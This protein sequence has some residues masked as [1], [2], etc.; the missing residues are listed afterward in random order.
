MKDISGKKVSILSDSKYQLGKTQREIKEKLKTKGAEIVSDYDKSDFI[1]LGKKNRSLHFLNDKHKILVEAELEAQEPKHFTYFGGLAQKLFDM[2][3]QLIAMDNVTVDMFEI[4]AGLTEKEFATIEKRLKKPLPKSVKEFYS[5]FG[6]VKMLWHF[7]NPPVSYRG[8]YHKGLYLHSG[9]HNGCINILPLRKFLFENWKNPEL[10]LSLPADKDIRLFDLYADYHIIGCELSNDE[11]PKVYLGSDHG[12]NFELINDL[13]FSVY[14]N[15]VIGIYGYVNRFTNTKQWIIG[16]NGYIFDQFSVEDIKD[17]ENIQKLSTGF[18]ALDSANAAEIENYKR[19]SWEEI[20]DLL[21]Q[22]AYKEAFVKARILSSS[23]L[24]ACSVM[25]DVWV[26]EE[27]EEMFYKG[28]AAFSGRGFDLEKYE[29]ETEQR[30]YLD[31]P[32]YGVLKKTLSGNK[33]DE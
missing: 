9:Q 32:E 23:D 13:T 5:V 27:N 21:S 14:I 8:I 20:K 3:R 22:E 24:Y 33:G 11:D 10:Y 17:D 6:H 15:R 18:V 2:L 1:I 16:G 28:I 29:S 26:I 31:K 12:V 7:S 19:K 25:L 30:T 4:G